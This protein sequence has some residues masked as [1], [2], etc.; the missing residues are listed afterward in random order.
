MQLNNIK[1]QIVQPHKNVS[2]MDES[3]NKVRTRSFI[4]GSIDDKGIFSIATKPVTHY[5]EEA[6]SAEARRLATVYPGKAFFHA[7]LLGA[8][9]ARGVE[10]I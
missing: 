9:V 8:F 4:V 5:T 6:A 3:L 7:Q 1:Y 2:N 10:K